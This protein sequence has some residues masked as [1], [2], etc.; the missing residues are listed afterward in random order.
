MGPPHDDL[1]TWLLQAHI[2]AALAAS[3]RAADH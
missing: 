3:T 1:R 2:D